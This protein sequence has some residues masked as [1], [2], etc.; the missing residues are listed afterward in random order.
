MRP[1]TLPHVPRVPGLHSGTVVTT[2]AVEADPPRNLNVT[3]QTTRVSNSNV[4][5]F[6]D[7]VTVT[8]QV[9]VRV[10]SVSK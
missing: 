9:R 10:Q 1:L 8:V 2:S 5:P 6:V 3:V 7:N 4:L